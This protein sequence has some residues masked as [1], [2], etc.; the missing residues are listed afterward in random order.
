MP[1]HLSPLQNIS[2]NSMS[3]PHHL[4]S[5]HLSPLKNNSANLRKSPHATSPFS[6]E[7]IILKNQVVC[8]ITFLY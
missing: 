2:E 7:K 3:M 4:M 1:C 6:I 8:R 5:R